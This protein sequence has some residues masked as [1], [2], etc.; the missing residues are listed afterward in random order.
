MGMYAKNF[1]INHGSV[2]RG[3]NT[4]I[5][6]AVQDINGAA[7]SLI[8]IN[9]AVCDENHSFTLS[10]AASINT[11]AMSI[12]IPSVR[13]RLKFVRKLSDNPKYCNTKNVIKNDNGKLMVA[14]AASLH[15]TKKI[16]HKN[17]MSNVCRALFHKFL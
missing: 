5:V 4:T 11:T 16:T 13:T 1:P 6:V 17:T 8:A 12:I 9:I 7:K 14:I 3:I 10:E 2:N 15:H